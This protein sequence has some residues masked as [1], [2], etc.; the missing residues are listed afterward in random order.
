MSAMRDMMSGA[1]RS[2][3]RRVRAEDARVVHR[4][5]GDDPPPGGVGRGVVGRPGQAVGVGAVGARRV[6]GLDELGDEEALTRRRGV[7]AQGDRRGQRHRR[8]RVQGER[9]GAAGHLDAEPVAAEGDVVAGHPPGA[10]GR[11]G[12]QLDL[13]PVADLL[14][15]QADDPSADRLAGRQGG[16]LF[17]TATGGVAHHQVRVERLGDVERLVLQ[18]VGFAFGRTGGVGVVGVVRRG[19]GVTRQ[20]QVGLVVTRTCDPQQQR[21]HDPG[22]DPSPD[23]DHHA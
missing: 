22:G 23:A 20:G 10:A 14:H 4:V 16:E 18:G 9:S 19:R 12:G 1:T 13:D 5:H 15:D 3:P 6:G 8:A 2:S 7:G 11:P 21:R 17:G